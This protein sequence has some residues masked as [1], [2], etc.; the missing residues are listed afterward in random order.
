[1]IAYVSPQFE[2]RNFV[3]NAYNRV[4]IR[5]TVPNDPK[6]LQ[7]IE[8]PHFTYH[9]PMYFHLKC[10]KTN[11]ELFAGIADVGVVLS[12]Q[13]AMPWIDAVSAPIRELRTAGVSRCNTQ[14]RESELL[15]V[16]PDE[17][18]SVHMAI[19]FMSAAPAQMDSNS[20]ACERLNAGY[21]VCLRTALVPPQIATLS[22]FHSC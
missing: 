16:T 17:D 19:D 15:I 3:F 4:V 8:N 9:P 7:P 5:Y 21:T 11:Q 12:Q 14:Q 10:D 13:D 2:S 20:E 18:R 22:W 6:A 1:M